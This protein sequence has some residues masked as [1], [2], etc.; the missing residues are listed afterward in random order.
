MSSRPSS[1][2]PGPLGPPP[3]TTEATIALGEVTS[4]GTLGAYRALVRGAGEPHA[5]RDDLVGDA[6]QL[7]RRAPRRPMLALSHVT[8]L[9][10]ADVQS[11]ARFEFFNRE[12]EDPRFTLLVP[13]QRPNEAFTAHAVE[14][15]VATLN[16]IRQAPVA[17]GEL[18]LALTTGDAIDNGQ[19]NELLAALALLEGG[20]VALSPRTPGAPARYEGVQR[21][22]WPDQ[23]FWRPDGPGAL[24][25]GAVSPDLLTA[26]FGYPQH[27]G[28]LD[29]AVQAFISSGLNLPW[30][31]CYGNHEGLIQ[32]VGRIT[33]ELAAALVGGSKPL[34]LPADLDRDTAYEVFVEGAHAFLAG[35][36]RGITADPRRRPVSRAEFVRAH[37]GPSARP[38]G[39]GFDER[40][41]REGTAYY[42]HD[43]AAPAA[44]GGA[45][46]F[47]ALD[48]TC[49]LGGA[50]GA[51]DAEQLT[52][53]EGQLREVHSRWIGPDGDPV[54]A[55][56]DDRLVVLF[57]HHGLD[58]LTNRRGSGVLDGTGF[59]AV[60]PDG[61]AVPVVPADDVL[62]L[63]HRYPNVVA[64]INGHTHTNGVRARR[65]PHPLPDGRPGGFWEITTCA[66]VDWPCQTRIV[67]LIGVSEGGR[68]AIA[69]ACTMVDHDSPLAPGEALTRRELAA[70]HRELAANA[71]MPGY[72]A[73]LAGAPSDRN[74]V[75]PVATSLAT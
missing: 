20:E 18:G 49:L 11:P 12:Y 75:L 70:L 31:A 69:L 56:G 61:A 44:P 22:D 52:W 28:V 19:W 5:V 27:P 40:N 74:V 62:A 24:P 7:W 8:D 72:G 34:E 71:P 53:L 60:G 39:H 48:T 16:R 64:W 43:V 36:Q 29:R 68:G 46:R 30:L 42:S 9:Q 59:A 63:V 2:R 37:F 15:T 13:T 65:S 55:G 1:P 45:I 3:L 54:D 73:R 6:E 38:I 41:R 32:G 67:E 10:L 26:G 4:R 47:I 57:S 35:P 17:G 14:A 25:G 23:V 51:I 33:P 50:D 21:T 66:V 58:T